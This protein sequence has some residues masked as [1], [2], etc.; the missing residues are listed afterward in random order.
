[1]SESILDVTSAH[2]ERLAKRRAEFIEQLAKT[3]PQPCD[4]QVSQRVTY[5]N[6]YGVVFPGKT[7]IGFAETDSFYGRFVHLDTD[8]YWMPVLPER[9]SPE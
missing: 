6:E 9:V 8:C 3:P 4:L 7:I 5:T 1:V 2:Q